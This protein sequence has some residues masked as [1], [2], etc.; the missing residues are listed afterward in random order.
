MLTIKTDDTRTGWDRR[1]S[2]ELING[3]LTTVLK[4]TKPLKSARKVRYHAL[5]V[6]D[7]MSADGVLKNIDAEDVD[8]ARKELAEKKRGYGLR[9]KLN[10]VNRGL[11]QD[12][13]HDMA[14]LMADKTMPF[15]EKLKVSAKVLVGVGAAAVATGV[16][17]Q[18]V[19]GEA[20]YDKYLGASDEKL[21]SDFFAG[22][23]HYVSLLPVVAGAAAA[24][25]TAKIGVS[26]LT[27]PRS[28]A[29]AKKF[30][31]YVDIKHAQVALKQLKRFLKAQKPEK[32]ADNEKNVSA[33]LLREKA[34]SR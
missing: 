4:E 14:G 16:F 25:M 9:A 18:A 21:I 32:T 19:F 7:E 5:A 6:I 20:N 2:E 26:V 22:N 28:E 29:E 15:E 30:D 34:F 1:E 23:D 31:E 12:Y 24:A 27:R 13:V 11:V 33:A 3:F 8:R 10:Y 17:A